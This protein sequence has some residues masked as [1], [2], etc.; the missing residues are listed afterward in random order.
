M[1]IKLK[2]MFSDPNQ[3]TNQE[4]VNS[5]TGNR[6]Y[7]RNNTIGYGLAG[8]GLG[9][10]VGTGIA[11][12]TGKGRRALTGAITEFGSGRG[13]K[14]GN[15][16]GKIGAK[17]AAI[18]TAAGAATLGTLGYLRGRH[19]AKKREAYRTALLNKMNQAP[20]AGY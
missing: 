19:K 13:L 5:A 11:L 20:S 15:M 6:K 7:K 9:A 1:I 10:G 16:A 3:M 8:A 14:L 12:S 2:R 17:G 4:L 18:G